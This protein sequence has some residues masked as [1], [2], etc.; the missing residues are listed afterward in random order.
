MAFQTIPGGVFIPDR[1]PAGFAGFDTMVLDAAS[2]KA[3]FVFPAPKTGNV[4]KIAFAT[5]T[6]TNGATVDVRLETVSAADGHPTGTLFGANTN[7]SLVIANG[8][9]NAW[10]TTAAL[11]ADAAVTRG[12]M[13][14]AVIVNPAVSPGNMQIAMGGTTFS[15]QGMPYCDL[16]TASY[17]K[18]Q[19][20]PVVALEY[21]DGSYA[22]VGGVFP[23]KAVNINQFGQSS[24]PDEYALKFKL[25]VPVRVCGFWWFGRPNDST[26]DA[27]LYDSD[28]TTALL[29]KDNDKDIDFGSAANRIRYGLFSSSAELLANT[30]YRLGFAADAAAGTGADL[31]EFEVG[32]A[33]VMD[34][35]PGGQN[36]HQ[37]TRVNA[38]AWTDVTTKRPCAGVIVDGFSDGAG[39][40]GSR[41]VILGG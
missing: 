8:D 37:S 22:P 9:D 7:A 33:A 4:R 19:R 18:Q 40:G 12:D 13:L 26:L 32:S 6:V 10:L 34:A 17:A 15:D 23:L 25:T 14:A 21:D 3:A 24:T 31:F 20:P 28:G 2:E 35:M 27:T 41:A 11:T 38:G 29:T 16:F 36:F 5:R 30:F 1:F 39:G